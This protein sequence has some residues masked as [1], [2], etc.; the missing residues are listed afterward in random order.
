[1]ET[2]KHHFRVD[3]MS[4][5]KISSNQ[6]VNHC[7]LTQGI[8]KPSQ[9]E[10]AEATRLLE[11]IRSSIIAMGTNELKSLFVRGAAKRGIK[12]R[13]NL[14]SNWKDLCGAWNSHLTLQLCKDLFELMVCFFQTDYNWMTRKA[15]EIKERLNIVIDTTWTDECFVVDILKKKCLNLCWKTFGKGRKVG[16]GVGLSQKKTIKGHP[17][18]DLVKDCKNDRFCYQN[19]HCWEVLCTI[20][21]VAKRIQEE[22]DQLPSGATYNPNVEMAIRKHTVLKDDDDDSIPPDEGLRKKGNREPILITTQAQAGTVE[23]APPTE[24]LNAPDSVLTE[25]DVPPA[26]ISMSTRQGPKRKTLR[27]KPSPQQQQRVSAKEYSND[28]DIINGTKTMTMQAEL[29]GEV[30]QTGDVGDLSTLHPSFC[31]QVL[32]LCVMLLSPFAANI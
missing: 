15:R 13:G 3:A 22:K 27:T 8:Q 5:G 1:M 32:F 25:R 16:H 11:N 10:V 23:K 21:P 4:D 31:T 20:D 7:M 6:A 12:H 24:A 29:E 14:V 30:I 28:S 2:I 26:N 17:M 9:D 19:V 18:G